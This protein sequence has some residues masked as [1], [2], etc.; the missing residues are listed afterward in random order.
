ML[1]A[2]FDTR[3]L[4]KTELEKIGKSVI[5]EVLNDTFKLLPKIL[6]FRKTIQLRGKSK[7]GAVPGGPFTEITKYA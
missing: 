2:G 4:S 6:G 3:R 5:A 1:V 7:I